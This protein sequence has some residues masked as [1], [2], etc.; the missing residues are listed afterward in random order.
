MYAS[1]KKLIYNGL[2][3]SFDSES[4]FDDDNIDPD[5]VIEKQ[6]LEADER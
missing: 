5:F 1:S 4:E 2:L 3:E 6:T